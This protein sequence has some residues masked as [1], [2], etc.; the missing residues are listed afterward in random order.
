MRIAPSI[1][2]A[3][4]RLAGRAGEGEAERVVVGVVMGEEDV[5]RGR[6]ALRA[7]TL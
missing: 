4:P 6:D 1:D 2:T 5:G 7:L 3:R